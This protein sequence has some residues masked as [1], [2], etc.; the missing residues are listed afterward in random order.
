MGIGYK[1]IK[2]NLFSFGYS[3][4]HASESGRQC[5]M[6]KSLGDFCACDT[7]NLRAALGLYDLKF[8]LW[9]GALGMSIC[10]H[11]FMKNLS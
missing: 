9:L 11:M 6:Y 10:V 5:K 3:K 1:H 7:T 8:K 2:K 4:R